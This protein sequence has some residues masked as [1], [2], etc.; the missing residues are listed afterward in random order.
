ML[1]R[2]EKVLLD[3]IDLQISMEGKRK[4]KEW[5]NKGPVKIVVSRRVQVASRAGS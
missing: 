1:H 3:F 5:C 4:L 2:N